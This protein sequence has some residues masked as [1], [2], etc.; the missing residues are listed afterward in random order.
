VH[1][2]QR[3]YR[4]NIV[5]TLLA[6]VLLSSILSSFPGVL[7]FSYNAFVSQ[8]ESTCIPQLQWY[9]KEYDFGAIQEGNIY[10]TT[11]DIW[12][13]GTGD[14]PWSLQLRDPY[15]TAEPM[16]GSS[17]GEH[18]TVKVT[19]N[20]T[21]LLPGDYEGN[22]Y[23]H[24]EGDYIFFIFF[25]ITP[26]KLAYAPTQHDFGIILERDSL[27]TSF[28]I[29]NA[30]TGILQWTLQSNQSWVSYH[31][32]IGTSTGETDTITVT[33]TT[34]EL[35]YGDNDGIIQ[36]FSNGGN[37]NATFF[38]HLNYPPDKPVITGPYSGLIMH[39]YT[40]TISINDKE[41]DVLWYQ[42]DWGDSSD[43]DDEW[44]GPYPSGEEITLSHAWERKGQYIIKVKTKDSFDVESPLA[45]HQITLSKSKTIARILQYILGNRMD[46][47]SYLLI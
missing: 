44:I 11:F 39:Q 43:Q 21:G 8:K 2:S 24:S 7:S 26:E 19:L 3:L 22:V 4:N 31:P 6:I 32:T 12:N 47:Y 17:S 23:L 20:T 5:A 38:L 28:D 41:N 25:T 27:E 33:L 37:A 35:P 36:I 42:I 46:T 16:S 15:V 30:G 34:A 1:R 45:T 9:P 14:M 10:Q 13:N 40:F 18:D 29:W